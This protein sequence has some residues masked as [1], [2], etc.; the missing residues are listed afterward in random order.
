LTDSFAGIEP[1]D[2]A[3]FVIAQCLGALAA[4]C[5]MRWLEGRRKSIEI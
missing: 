4:V 1:R 3:G 5:L 2:V